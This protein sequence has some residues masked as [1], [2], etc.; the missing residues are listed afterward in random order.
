MRH[1]RDDVILRT[2]QEFNLLD[3][4]VTNLSEA[5]WKRLLPRPEQKTP[6]R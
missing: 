1:T 3:Q 6:G 5:D 4:L 2:I